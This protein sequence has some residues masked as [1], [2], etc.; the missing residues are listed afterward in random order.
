MPVIRGTRP[1]RPLALAALLVAVA[2]SCADDGAA[3]PPGAAGGVVA[4]GAAAAPAAYSPGD[5]VEFVADEFSFSPMQLTAEPGTYTGVVT[6]TGTILHDITFE[7]QETVTVAA[8]ETVEFEFTVPAEGIGFSCSIPG[9]TEA[10]M[11]GF[12]ATPNG[13]TAPAPSTGGDGHGSNAVT[14][15]D[16]AA[17]PDAAPYVRRDP[18]APDRG[19]GEGI[20][21]VPG[22]APDGGDL[23]EWEL[24]IEE[25]LM[26]VADGYEQY[27][28]TFGGEVPGPV[29]R[30]RVGDTVRVHLVNPTEASVSHSIDYHAS[31]VSME[32]EMASIAPGEDLVYEFTT[33]Y[34]GVWMYHCGTAP[35]LHHIANGMFGMVIVEPEEGLEPVDEELFFVQHEWYLGEQGEPASLAKANQAAPAPD[36][37][38]FNGVA[39]QYADEPIEIATG[40]EVRMFVL[41]VGPS[42]DTSFH[43]VG[44][45]FHRVTKEGV[46]LAEGNT[47]SWGA[48]AVD[49]SPAQGAVIE[50][51]T[52]EDGT[53]AFVNHA[54][55]FP[56]RGA[57]GL[58]H[59]S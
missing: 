50:M 40:D 28:W 16:V 19:E 49:L 12:V 36:F 26:T 43:V 4:E 44:T 29:L 56:G 6:N 53:Y 7:G 46:H 13:T 18:R 34:A 8:G 9:H 59:A 47:G 27:V 10:G 42:V 14:A 58:F 31:Q 1:L 52:A 25:K 38:M 11:T 48:Q 22:G 51:R 41:N 32:D 24:V 37:Q 55:N 2:A 23:I 30:T 54:F 39:G 21:L 35:V 17:N 33:D 3:G 5:T 45:I 20:T 57:L 15:A